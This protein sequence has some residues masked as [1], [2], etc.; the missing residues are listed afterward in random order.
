MRPPNARGP[1]HL[2]ALPRVREVKIGC[3]AI[4]LARWEQMRARRT[5]LVVHDMVRPPRYRGCTHHRFRVRHAGP[6]LATA[7]A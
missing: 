7:R 1:L 2:F 4:G 3:L 5:I 6:E